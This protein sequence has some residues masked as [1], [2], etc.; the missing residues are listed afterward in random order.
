M[1]LSTASPATQQRIAHALERL[2][3]RKNA[4][5]ETPLKRKIQLLKVS[6][7]GTDPPSSSAWRKT[8][9]QQNTDRTLVL[10]LPEAHACYGQVNRVSPHVPS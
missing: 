4:W 1:V 8:E 6:M 9:L 10:L 5:K 2:Q 3:S 7:F